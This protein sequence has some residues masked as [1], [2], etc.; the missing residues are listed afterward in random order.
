MSNV[1]IS[2]HFSSITDTVPTDQDLRKLVAKKI[3]DS[4][5]LGLMLGM[6]CCQVEIFKNDERKTVLVNM[7]ILTTWINSETKIPTTWRT[8]LQA[9]VDMEEKKLARDITNELEQ[10]A[11]GKDI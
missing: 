2:N 7:K 6:D 5:H 1:S 10:R 8:L 3:T 4:Q 9:L 11:L